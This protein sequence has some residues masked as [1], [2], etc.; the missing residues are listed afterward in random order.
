MVFGGWWSFRHVAHFPPP[1]LDSYGRDMCLKWQGEKTKLFETWPLEF[2]IQNKGLQLENSSKWI[3]MVDFLLPLE[4]SPLHFRRTSM[5]LS[6]F[7]EER[8][9]L[10]DEQLKVG[11]DRLSFFVRAE[12]VTEFFFVWRVVCGVSQVRSIADDF[13]HVYGWFMVICIKWKKET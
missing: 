5:H 6:A 9:D 10:L 11:L 1:N 2:P 4:C 7:G 8:A 13:H 12:E 3:K